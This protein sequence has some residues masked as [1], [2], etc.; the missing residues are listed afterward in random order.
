MPR[1]KKEKVQSITTREV[2]LR[3]ATEN[4]LGI[5]TV[6]KVVSRYHKIIEEEL[7]NKKPFSLGKICKLDPIN[8]DEEPKVTMKKA[9]RTKV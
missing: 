3:I 6:S 4:N 1:S 7:G 5:Y 9:S 8:E 2:I